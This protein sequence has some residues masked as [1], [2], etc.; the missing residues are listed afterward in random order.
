MIKDIALRCSC[1]FNIVDESFSCRGSKDGFENTVVFRARVAIQDPNAD[2]VVN[3]ITNWVQSS[4]SISVD[5]VT[6]AIDPNC[7]AMLDSFHSPDCV[8]PSSSSPSKTGLIVGVVFGVVCLI[9]LVIV[10]VVLI[11]LYQ[12]RQASHRLV[13]YY[14]TY[15]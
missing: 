2:D 6:L 7:P 13:V 5:A 15:M 8:T 14:G 11:V 10:I 3:N 4:P 12:R 1:A 9:I